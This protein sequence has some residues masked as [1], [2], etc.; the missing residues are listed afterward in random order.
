MCAATLSDV[1]NL[2]FLPQE[3]P[4]PSPPIFD[5]STE[6]AGKIPRRQKYIHP[7]IGLPWKKITLHVEKDYLLVAGILPL[8]MR[9]HLI[10]ADMFGWTSY[11]KTDNFS[12]ATHN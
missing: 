11:A 10:S 8:G 2:P 12:S 6:V 5:A 4:R 1:Q 3:W 7:I 9:N